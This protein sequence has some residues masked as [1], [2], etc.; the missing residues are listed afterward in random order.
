MQDLATAKTNLGCFLRYQGDSQAAEK[1][2]REA[3][4]LAKSMNDLGFSSEMNQIEIIVSKPQELTAVIDGTVV[5][6][7]SGK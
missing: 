6:V 1:E 5:K 2:H 4:S 7:G 3:L